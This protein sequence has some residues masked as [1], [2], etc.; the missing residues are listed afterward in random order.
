MAHGVLLSCPTRPQNGSSATRGI[1]GSMAVTNRPATA[2]AMREAERITMLHTPE[3]T[4]MDRAAT[5]IAAE[6]GGLS[7]V[8]LLVGAGNNGGDALL[9]GAL[10]A[11]QGANVTAVLLTPDAH[12]R[13][14]AMLTQAGGHVLE[15]QL[16]PE[17]ARS[18]LRAAVA[19][20]DGIVGLGGRPGLRPDALEA[21][22]AIPQTARVIAVDLPSGLDPD[23]GEASAPHVTAHVTVT[24]T[25]PKAC[26]VED[27]AA[28]SA[29]RVVLADVG[30]DLPL[31]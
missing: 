27:P 31:E 3:D 18:A 13:G 28:A 8:V 10:L 17:G 6:C 15:W 2:A 7:P 12:P 20:I 22:A 29:G 19:V 4:L 25:A 26:L 5:A 16:S 14:L 21:V 24:F 9:A 1:V 30:V 23:S 11:S